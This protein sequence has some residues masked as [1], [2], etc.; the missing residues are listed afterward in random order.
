V[1]EAAARDHA[2]NGRAAAGVPADFSLESIRQR[3]IELLQERKTGAG[4]VQRLV[5]DRLVWIARYA[6][7]I[8]WWELAVDD[9]SGRVVR[10]QRSR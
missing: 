9:Q 2:E 8:A 10:V 5:E 6:K 3:Y 4:E 7:D 1:V